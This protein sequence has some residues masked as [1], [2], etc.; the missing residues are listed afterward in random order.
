[1]SNH[2]VIV[3]KLNSGAD[4]LACLVGESDTKI[5]VQHPHYVKYSGNSLSLGLIP[6]CPLSDETYFEFARDKVDFVVLANAVI[7]N[8]FISMIES[9]SSQK[10]DQLFEQAEEATPQQTVQ[11]NFVEGNDTK[12]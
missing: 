3:M 9:D 12:H 2:C 8:N 7:A 1:M 11:Y 4:M 10:L 6:Y 5:R